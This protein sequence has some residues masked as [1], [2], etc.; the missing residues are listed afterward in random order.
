MEEYTENLEK[1]IAI[2][3]AVHDGEIQSAIEMIN[4]LLPELLDNNH[5]LH[6]H[7]LVGFLVVGRI[8]LVLPQD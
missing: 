6:F 2:R 7:L 3:R 5:Y 8:N 1:R 4:D